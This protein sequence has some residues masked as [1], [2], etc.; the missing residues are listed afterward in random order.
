[1]SAFKRMFRELHE[2]DWRELT[3]TEEMGAWPSTVKAVVIVALV[4]ALFI[5]GYVLALRGLHESDRR[6]MG[7]AAALRNEL[8]GLGASAA[9]LDSFREWAL[10]SEAPYLEILRQLPYES[11]IPALIDEIAALGLAFNL[12]FKTL[13]LPAETIGAH[14]V[15]QAI[16]IRAVGGY[17]ELGEFL[18]G[19]AGL[20]RIVTSHDFVLTEAGPGRLELNLAAR[21]YRYL[22]LSD[23]EAA[24]VAAASP[25]PPRL[26]EP[27]AIGL[28]RYEPES[29]RDPFAMPQDR[30]APDSGRSE[31]LAQFS[32]EDLRLVGLL[33]HG[34]RHSGLILDPSG[35]VH[36]VVAG[37]SLG[38][39]GARIGQISALGV[40]L[41]EWS[42][43][44]METAAPRKTLLTWENDQ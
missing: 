37:D 7:E 19:L 38:S 30:P 28:F 17:H 9:R 2:F 29:R 12:E 8:A 39:E 22:P 5:G 23:A 15:E 6:L 1:M 32:L 11:E 33:H 16:D 40:E 26:P 34:N 43:D 20:D 3:A 24:A 41:I 42:G 14:Y 44:G 31:P 13:D 10:A 18:A 35:A 21:S 36:R 25:H 4:A 27:L